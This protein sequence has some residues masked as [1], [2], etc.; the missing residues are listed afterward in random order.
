MVTKQTAK[1]LAEQHL[2]AFLHSEMSAVDGRDT[3]VEV[4]ALRPPVTEC[5]VIYIPQR[6]IALR[7]SVVILV[8]KESGEVVYHG[9]ANDEG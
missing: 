2:F 5:W 1:A 3:E 7:S 4:Y 9:P 8:A 6:G